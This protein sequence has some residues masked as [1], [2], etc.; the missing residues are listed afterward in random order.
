[1]DEETSSSVTPRFSRA[2]LSCAPN[3]A[4]RRISQL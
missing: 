3:D 1:V 4:I 2:S